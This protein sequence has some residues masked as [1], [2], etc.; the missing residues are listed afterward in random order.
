[1]LKII[2]I[3]VLALAS[4]DLIGYNR[5]GNN[6]FGH[7]R[8]SPRSGKLARLVLMKYGDIS[9]LRPRSQRQK[10]GGKINRRNLYMRN[11]LRQR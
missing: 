6:V 2:A 8:N 10:S 4:C 3:I 11:M 1:M 7:V 5:L 9:K